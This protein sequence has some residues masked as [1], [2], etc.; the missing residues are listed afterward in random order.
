M[1][2]LAALPL[3]VEPGTLLEYGMNTDVLGRIVEVASGMEFGQF[4]A[5]R[6]LKP[7]AMNDSGFAVQPDKLQ[8]LAEPQVNPATGKRPPIWQVSDKP[9]WS[10]GGHGMVSTSH[11][12]ARFCQML[13]NGGTLDGVRSV[14][15]ETIALMR[16]D[17]LPVAANIQGPYVD[18]GYGFGLGW[19]VH[20]E[21]TAKRI[22]GSIGDFHWF[23]ASGTYFWVDPKERLF[24]MYLTQTPGVP[25]DSLRLLTRQQVY[26]G[27]K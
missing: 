26:G 5:T 17:H 7:L 18:N 11:D 12:Y 10:A 22:P 9:V 8:R 25:L 14:S 13:L 24:V 20:T 1:T 15:A 6:I 2:K 3:Q 16:R 23:G 21:E 19:S 27:L 4:A